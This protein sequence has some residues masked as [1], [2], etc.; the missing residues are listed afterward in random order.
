MAARHFTALVSLLTTL[1]VGC[2]SNARRLDVPAVAKI[3]V[4]STTTAEVEKIFGRPSETVIGPKERAV[5]RYYFREF[6]VKNDVRAYERHEH[7]GDILFRTLSLR[8]GPDRIIE[9]KLHDE[10]VT[11]IHRLNEWFAAGPTLLPENLNFIRKDAT[12]KAEL[13]DALGEPTSQTMDVQGLPVLIWIGGK[14]RRD[15][16]A[17]A[18]VRQL[19]VLLNERGMVK[20]YAVVLQDMP[21][22]RGDWR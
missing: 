21:G 22:V 18:E 2:V 16:L 11:P 7:P 9:Q 3:K 19:I 4:G 17:D 20:D 5:A 14:V 8:Y 6:R 10:S 1:L 15:R 13:T 12:T